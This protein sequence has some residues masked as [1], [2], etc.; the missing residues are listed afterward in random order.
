MHK[1]A[2]LVFIFALIV[3]N[4]LGSKANGERSRLNFNQTS[5]GHRQDDSV[6]ARW[7]WHGTLHFN[8][9]SKL[10]DQMHPKTESFG[11]TILTDQFVATTLHGYV[12]YEFD[13]ENVRVRVGQPAVGVSDEFTQELPISGAFQSSEDRE[14]PRRLV[15]FKLEG[16]LQFSKFVQPICLWP[17][18]D[19]T[20]DGTTGYLLSFGRFNQGDKSHAISMPIVSK[21]VCIREH[22]DF[23]VLFIDYQ[24]FCAG[25]RNG[26]GPEPFDAGS[27][28]FVRRDND[29]FL[30]GLTFYVITGEDNTSVKTYH[31]IFLDIT[32]FRKW[33]V[34]T[35]ESN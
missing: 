33:V 31:V 2:L 27:G 16:R 4:S 24:T 6:R 10:T 14:E 18:G 19:F 1:L 35:I 28:L 11:V 9:S 8:R 21:E 15:L 12:I 34:S 13:P 22:A 20:L 23:G 3:K 5:C 17:E 26:S 29:W 32:Y 7:P 30:R 25:A